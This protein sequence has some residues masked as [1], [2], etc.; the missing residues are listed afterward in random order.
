VVNAPG[1]WNW[2]TLHTRDPERATAFYAEVFGWVAVPLDLGVGAPATMLTLPGY[3]EHLAA[4]DPHLRARHA[5]EG[6]PPGFSDAIGWLE[7]MPRERWGDRV[8]SHWSVTFAVAD[9]DAV[10]IR[11]VALGGQVLDPPVTLGPARLAT[12]ADPDGVRF[13]VNSY[14]PA[15]TAPAA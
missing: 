7:P 10:A 1:S 4:R 12:L 2:S 5:A 15:V 14:R 6:V 11:A 8:P 9:A 3:G 13:A